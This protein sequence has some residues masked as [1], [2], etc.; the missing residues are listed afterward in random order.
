MQATSA[1]NG[2]FKQ[3]IER[4]ALVR[5]TEQQPLCQHEGGGWWPQMLNIRGQLIADN[6]V[7]QS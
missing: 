5:A 4:Y 3:I 1:Q 6:D 2:F 7:A